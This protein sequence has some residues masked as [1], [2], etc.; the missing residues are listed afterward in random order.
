MNAFEIKP[1]TT[2][3]LEAIGLRAAPFLVQGASESKYA[4]RSHLS[5]KLQD[6]AA[7][8]SLFDLSADILGGDNQ[9]SGFVEGEMVYKKTVLEPASECL[10]VR[11][12][13]LVFEPWRRWR[14]SEIHV[15][16]SSEAVPLAWHQTMLE[17][18]FHT[19]MAERIGVKRTIYTIQGFKAPIAELFEALVRFLPYSGIGAPCSIKLERSARHWISPGFENFPPQLVALG[20]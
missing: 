16:V 20:R 8:R 14:E 18:G 13:E 5:S 4:P 12:G 6:G 10:E 7:F 1:T 9:F 3:A 19:A 2:T 17:M 11:F 15:G